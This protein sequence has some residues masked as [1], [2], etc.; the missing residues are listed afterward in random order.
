MQR[1]GRVVRV[2]D[3]V[4]I[5]APSYPEGFGGISTLRQTLV[6]SDEGLGA[7]EG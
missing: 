7:Y 2:K 4:S 1:C 5:L 3:I 6:C